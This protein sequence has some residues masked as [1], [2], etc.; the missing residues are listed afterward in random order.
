L[1]GI[2]LSLEGLGLN[3]KYFVPWNPERLDQSARSL[4][5]AYAEL[6]PRTRN[7]EQLSTDGCRCAVHRFGGGRNGVSRTSPKG[8]AIKLNHYVLS[9]WETWRG[10]AA[11]ENPDQ[12][13]GNSD[14]K[15]GYKAV[16]GHMIAEHIVDSGCLLRRRLYFEVI[17]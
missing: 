1:F 13:G 17:V 3:Q 7:A 8:R 16:S 14:A 2:L 12:A 4:W 5:G 6:N 15:E 9:N 11:S 10:V